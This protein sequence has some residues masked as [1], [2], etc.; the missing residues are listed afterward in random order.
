MNED[1]CLEDLDRREITL[2]GVTEVV[3]VAGTGP[4]EIVMTEMPG[5]SPGSVAGSAMQ[6]MPRVTT[7][8]GLD[9][10]EATCRQ[11][12]FGGPC[13]RWQR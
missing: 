6:D 9:R 5:I 12:P 7:Q 13:R 11:H 8:E 3:D 4:A 1:D 10:K 2:D